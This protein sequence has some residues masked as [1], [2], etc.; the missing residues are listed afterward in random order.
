M[1]RILSFDGGG[2]RGIFSLQIAAMVE[3]HLREALGRPDLVL[4]D[5][6]DFFAGTSTG[7]IIA[8]SLAWGAPVAEV[9]AMYL[10]HGADMFDRSRGWHR[11]QSTYRGDGLAA[12]FR[13]YF[14][15]DDGSPALL[16][17]AKLR[18]TLLIVMRNATTGSPW[19]VTNNPNGRFNDPALDDCNLR[20]PLWQLL[21]ASTAAPVFISRRRR[22]ALARSS[23]CSSMA[24]SRR[25]TIRRSCQC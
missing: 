7:A 1:K 12:M 2:I 17:S 8:A 3:R 19:P 22:L 15:E 25:S 5:V 18:P 11:L 9:E 21:R 20:L 14:R 23:S 10:T 6:V 13:S 4:A 16:G 24:A